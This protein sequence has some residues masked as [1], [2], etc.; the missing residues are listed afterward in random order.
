[1]LYGNLR[2][3]NKN[4]FCFELHKNKVLFTGVFIV[5]LLVIINGKA[6]IDYSHT[7]IFWLHEYSIYSGTLI[8]GPL[9]GRAKT[10][11]ISKVVTL[12][13]WSG[14]ILWSS[15]QLKWDSEKVV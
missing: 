12:S 15:G 14:C 2:I 8:I 7:K 4:T 3:D 11:Q 1:M 9:L 6:L 13:R 5:V 10:G